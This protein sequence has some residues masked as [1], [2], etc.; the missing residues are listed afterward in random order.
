MEFRDL[1]NSPPVE[2]KD[3]AEEARFSFLKGGYME[4]FDH[5]GMSF[6]FILTLCN[7]HG[8]FRG[9]RF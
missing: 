4:D 3:Q 7:G 6:S 2:E 1:I 8:V 5:Q 9:F